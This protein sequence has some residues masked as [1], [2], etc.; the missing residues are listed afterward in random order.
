MVCIG[1]FEG[2]RNE[3][4]REGELCLEKRREGGGKGRGDPGGDYGAYCLWRG[5]ERSSREGVW[6]WKGHEGEGEERKGEGVWES[7]R[8]GD[9]SFLLYRTPSLPLSLPPSLPL[10]KHTMWTNENTSAIHVHAL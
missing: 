6:V 10:R 7:G 8:I 1:S 5:R 2:P 3:G 9:L 4:E